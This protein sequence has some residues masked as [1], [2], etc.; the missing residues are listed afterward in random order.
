M[1]IGTVLVASC[2]AFAV[3]PLG[4]QTP[5]VTDLMRRGTALNNAG[6]LDSA[7]LVYQQAAK[8]APDVY[9]IHEGIGSILD[10]T[11]RYGEARMHLAKALDLAPAR[12]KI[13]VLRTIAISYA[14]ERK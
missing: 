10:L 4:A 3:M 11:G 5:E 8:L 2:L 7:L 13:N 12:A 9:N 14:F 1:R 6:Q